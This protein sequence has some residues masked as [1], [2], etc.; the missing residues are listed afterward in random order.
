MLD[1]QDVF[2]K[3][4]WKEE[5]ILFY[6]HFQDDIAIRQI[7]ITSR[8]KKLL[9]LNNLVESDSMLCDQKLSE[10]DLENND[11]ITREEFEENWQAK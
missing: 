6:F 2:I 9:S 7:E 3:K 11:F 10:L 8:G 5:D 1:I 4:Y